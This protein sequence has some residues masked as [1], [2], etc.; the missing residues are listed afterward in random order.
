MKLSI[1][2]ILHFSINFDLISEN[3]DVL[4]ATDYGSQF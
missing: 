4:L 3:R 1:V 2:L